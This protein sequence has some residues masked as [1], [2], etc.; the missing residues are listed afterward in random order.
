M[1]SAITTIDIKKM[2]FEEAMK[3]LES[4]MEILEKGEGTLEQSITAYER[5]MALADHCAQCL[6][7]A[8]ARVEKITQK[9]DGTIQTI[10]MNLIQDD[11]KK[12]DP[13]F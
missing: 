11:N 2:T 5:G 7:I 10:E 6:K 13:P 1:N 12:N 4:L 3:E 9:I 8:E